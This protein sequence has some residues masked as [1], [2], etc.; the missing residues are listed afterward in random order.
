MYI[1]YCFS[2]KTKK[3]KEKV[4]NQILIIVQY[5]YSDVARKPYVIEVNRLKI[6]IPHVDIIQ[7]HLL[8][9]GKKQNV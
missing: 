4:C 1:K 8:C 6:W 5:M 9:L 2:F 7:N 3:Y